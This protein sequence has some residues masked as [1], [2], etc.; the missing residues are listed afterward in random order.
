MSRLSNEKSAYLR[1]SA[2]QKIDWFPWCDEAFHKAKIEDKPVF[3]SSG[4]VWCHWCHVMAKECF[5]DDEVVRL[6]NENF[7]CIKLDRDERPEIDRRYQ[8]ALAVMGYG[9]GWPLSIF[10]T[11]DGRPFFGGT[12]FPLEDM[13]GRPGF[14]KVLRKVSEFYKS[15]KD[16]IMEYSQ[17]LMKAISFESEFYVGEIESHLIDISTKNILSLFDPQNGGFGSAPK[18]PMPGAIEFLLNRYFF[19]GD[20]AIS[21][22]VVKTLTS[23]AKG[24]LYDQIGGGFHR[25]STDEAWIIPHFEKMADDNAWLLRNYLD[26]YCMFRKD[27]FKEISEGIIKFTQD[28][29]SDHDGCFYSSQDADVIPDDEGGYFTWTEKEIKDILSEEEYNI[30]SMHLLHERG[31][32]HHDNS[33]KVLFIAMDPEDIAKDTGKDLER[34][35]NII[36]IGKSKLLEQRRLRKSPFVDKTFYTSINGMMITSYLKAFRIL[37]DT[38][39]KEFAIKSLKRILQIYFVDNTI[40]HTDGVKGIL[41]DYIYIIE[42]LIAAYEVTADKY[43]LQTADSIMGVCLEKFWDERDGGF[44]DTE[45]D[46]LGMRLKAVEDIPHP[47]PNSLGIL[48]MFKLYHLTD[49]NIYLKFAE[50]ALRSF[51]SK[52]MDVSLQFGYYFIALDAYFNILRLS[53]YTSDM[54]LISEVLSSCRPYL[55]VTYG[56]DRGYVIPCLKTECYEPLYNSS[57]LKS[58]LVFKM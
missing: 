43:Y 54:D 22:A 27:F 15:N 16:K 45:Q 6:L 25:Y 26:A 18:F 58:F 37:K 44:F 52:I 3:L 29:L 40:L 24:G 48:L 50:K 2:H 35:K 8:L 17:E 1:H 49:K 13:F 9:G 4:A 11:P 31:A 7:I 41:E 21:F 46:I 30:L 47:A 39:I 20:K 38:K 51:Y 53:L 5:D 10:L 19:T 23:M 57:E 12:Y 55:N 14:K 34:I 56:E 42:A 32:M 36:S 33:K 28:V